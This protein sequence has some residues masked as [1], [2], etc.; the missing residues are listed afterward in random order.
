MPSAEQFTVGTATARPGEIVYGEL[1][2]LDHPTGGQEA[3]P[4]I[5]AQGRETGPTLWLTANI[6]GA[7]LTG[8]PV[9]HQLVSGDLAGRLRGTLVAI[10]SL[11]PAGLRTA[12]RLP[13]YSTTDPNRLWP[14]KQPP[15]DG[16]TASLS[17]YEQIARRVY[18]Q[19][20][21][22]GDYAIDLHNA[23]IRTIPFIILD[24][25]LYR[26]DTDRARAEGLASQ[27]T[28]LADAFSLSTV[29]E[30][31]A[32]KYVTQ[33]L[34]RS[35]SGSLVN[36]LGIPALTV[37]LG[38]TGAVDPAAV[39]AG[40]AGV[41]NALRWAGM[42]PGEPKPITACPVVKTDYPT[43]RDDT[44]RAPRAGILAPALEPSA[45]FGRGQLLAHLVDLWG[46]PLPGGE[47]AAP[48]DGWLIGWNNGLA[49]YAGQTVAS[50]AT[51]DDAPFV[52]PHPN[53]ERGMRSAE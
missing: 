29:R 17:P 50:L 10:P 37:E 32:E 25:A 30:A 49:K 27:L 39:A 24:R 12:Q 33:T 46:R 52:A 19:I 48:A 13:Y 21:R 6:H 53:A 23:A 31:A 35:V 22:R 42:L 26:D 28:A 36:V 7:E 41:T 11:N 2:V 20:A 44:A 43:K 18:E 8:L 3:L 38:M 1:P 5:I 4:V 34:H 15:R 45:R 16:A 47:I 9:I 14:A 40:V 51:R